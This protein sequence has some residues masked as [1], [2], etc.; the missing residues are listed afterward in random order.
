MRSRYP[1]ASTFAYSFGPGPLT[2]AIKALIIANVAAFFLTSIFPVVEVWA[3]ISPQ[4]VLERFAIWQPVTYM[5]VHGGILHI[6]FNMV[7]LWLFGVELE[8][9]WGSRKFLNYYFIA[10][11][12]GA[13][14]Q[15][16][17]GILP[18]GFADR[19]YYPSTIGASAAV[20]GIMLAYAMYFPNR[21]I[22]LW[23]L[24]PIAVKY[25][26]AILGAIAFFSMIRGEAGGVAHSAHLGGILAGYL[27]MNSGL[28]GGRFHPVAEIKYRYLKWRINRMR[29]KFDIVSGGRADDVNRRVH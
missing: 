17:L 19:F 18:F 16:V 22:L 27:Y 5:F 12:G 11:L 14:A 8:R 25:F 20:Y 21:Q 13:L 26:V 2:P 6:L 3:G 29:R 15:I 9:M 23:F 10:G 7:M 1:A 4:S 28:G 24:I